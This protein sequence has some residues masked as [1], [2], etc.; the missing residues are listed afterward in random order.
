MIIILAKHL[1]IIFPLITIRYW[2]WGPPNRL[3]NQRVFLCKAA[4]AI[5]IGLVISGLIGIIFPQ[6][7][8]FV[9]GIGQH[10]LPHAP[11]PSFLSNHATIAFIFS[12]SFLFWFRFWVGF[13]LFIP[14]FIIAWA[15]IFLG[16]HWPLDVA[17]AF[18]LA[19]LAC[20]ISQT[21]WVIGGY[22]LF[23]YIIKYYQTL[24]NFLIR[25][26]WFNP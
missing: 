21:V 22:K 23:P 16:V 20:G 7:R 18:V 14:A 15:R 13:I 11:T 2:F 4:L 9:L 26:G 10:F 19:I 8:P 6:E 17:G 24:F 1:I 3:F 12:F 5:I 25:K